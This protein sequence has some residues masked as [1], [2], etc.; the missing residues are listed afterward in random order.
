[1]D[2]GV[3]VDEESYHLLVTPHL[4]RMLT[5]L[6]RSAPAAQDAPLS[7]PFCASCKADL[8]ALGLTGSGMECPH[9]R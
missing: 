4:E 2:G 6:S 3:S 8:E 9:V 1:M 5:Q 7:T